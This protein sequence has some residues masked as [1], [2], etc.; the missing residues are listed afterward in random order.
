MSCRRPVPSPP[1]SGDGQLVPFSPYFAAVVPRFPASPEGIDSLH[2]A[3]ASACPL[4]R[5]P[6]N[7]AAPRHE[8]T[9]VLSPRTPSRSPETRSQRTFP[10]GYFNSLPVPDDGKSPPPASPLHGSHEDISSTERSFV[11]GYYSEHFEEV[12][13]IGRGSFGSV[14]VCR[15]VV[16]GEVVGIFA[17]KKVPVGDD[18]AYL[19]R[20]LSEVKILERVSQHPNVIQYHHS[21]LDVAR[22]SDFGPS[23]RCLFILMEYAAHGSLDA[24]VRKFGNALSDDAV[25]YFFLSVLRGLRHL[26]ERGILHRDIKPENVLLASNF[27]E[28]AVED[29]LRQD[30]RSTRDSRYAPRPVLADFGTSGFAPTPSMSQSDF[31]A[32]LRNRTGGTGTEDYM[33]PELLAEVEALSRPQSPNF[34]TPH[35]MSARYRGL[36]TVASDLY[37]MGVLLHQLAFGGAYPIRLDT[38]CGSS[39]LNAEPKGLQRPAEMATLIKALLHTDPKRRPISCAAILDMPEVCA[40]WNHVRTLPARDI[41]RADCSPA[42]FSAE[43]PAMRQIPKI[44]AGPQTADPRKTGTRNADASKADAAK[45]DPLHN[46]SHPPYSQPARSTRIWPVLIAVA[47]VAFS[48]GETHAR[49]TKPHTVH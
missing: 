3:R 7:F 14:H 13:L 24:V 18:A 25:W 27:A 36:H 40:K 49:W 43:M 23:V 8:P 30:Q 16:G 11:G 19:R 6:F 35:E 12:C 21:W 2:V 47:A 32:L 45:D 31:D 39:P 28:T 37:A 26:H 44:T 34:G 41:S 5:R 29:P 10:I 22:T 46:L 33:A 42:Q 15:H 20:V 4:C 17:V 48:A 38:S 9:V 1:M